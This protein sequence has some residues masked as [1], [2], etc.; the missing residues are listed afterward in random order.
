M[1]RYAVAGSGLMGRIIAK[2]L[3]NTESDARVTIIDKNESNLKN[4]ADYIDDTRLDIRNVNIADRNALVNATKDHSVVIGALP[5]GLSLEAIRAAIEARVSFVDL[6]GSR[7]EEKYVLHEEAKEAGC[8]IIPGFGVA[9]G[10]SNMCIGKGIEL[11]DETYDA[12]IYVGGIPVVKEPPLFYQTVYL[13][14]SV[15][16]A[17][18]RSGVILKAGEKVTIEPMSGLEK[19]VFPEPIGEL[20]AFYTDGLASLPMTVGEKVKHNLFEKTLRYPGHTERIQILRQC[21]LLKTDPVKVDG[22]SVIPRQLLFANLEDALKLGPEGDILVMRI[23]VSGTKDGKNHRHEFE[24]IDYYDKKK[25]ETAMARTTGFPA[26]IA[27]RMIT[28]GELNETGVWFPEQLFIN[29]RYD[30]I[31]ERLE[32]RGVKVTHIMRVLQNSK[33][34]ILI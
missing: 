15:F 34:D 12:Y 33:M 19:V 25:K 29:N 2:D 14:E 23:V 22:N 10:I 32:D 24:L 1:K 16:N 5:H 13:L 27:A 21:G 3:L 18:S 8:L 9:P 31:V 4:T 17:Y 6:V 28:D 20:E 11:L 26:A 30:K 7:P